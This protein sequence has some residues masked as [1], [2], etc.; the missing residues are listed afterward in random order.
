MKKIKYLVERMISIDY[1][2]LWKMLNVIHE[3]SEK[4]YLFLFYDMTLCAIRHGAGYMDYYLFHMY[5]IP[6]DKRATILT[7]GRNNELIAK[8]NHKEYI[9]LFHDKSKFNQKFNKYLK[10]DWIVLNHNEH[11]FESFLEKHREVILKPISGSCG[12]KIE[13]F[14]DSRILNGKYHKLIEDEQILVEEVICQHEKMNLLY[15]GAIN[16]IRAVSVYDSG[17]VHF[18]V[19]YL[20]IGNGTFV[21]NFNHGG[22]VVPIDEKTGR[23]DFPAIDK[24]GFLYQTHPI[25]GTSIIGFQIPMW[26]KVIS[27]VNDLAK[28]VPKVGMVGW[29]IAIGK[30][31]P[32]VVEGNEFPGHDIYQLP[33]HRINNIGVYPKFK[34][35]KKSN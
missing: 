6:E 8:Y 28:Q 4:S 35:I 9:E 19:A 7:R 21:D 10:R 3:E 32:L 22:M 11:A 31:G 34:E 15:K 12:K 13:K 1:K 24:E 25:S 16:T 17:K 23:I 26:K 20:R 27:L 14:S 18:V 2:N 5:D 30:D 29:D 33:P